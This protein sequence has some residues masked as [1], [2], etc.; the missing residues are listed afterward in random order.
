MWWCTI[1]SDQEWFGKERTLTPRSKQVTLSPQLSQGP[2]ETSA[3]VGQEEV[4]GCMAEVWYHLRFLFG[5]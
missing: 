1:K 3:Y 2:F 5:L 4:C